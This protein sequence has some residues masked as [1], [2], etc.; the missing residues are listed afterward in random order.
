MLMFH[1]WQPDLPR[2]APVVE[3]RSVEFLMCEDY[4]IPQMAAPKYNIEPIF[5]KEL[6]MCDQLDRAIS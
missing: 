1:S 2:F 5:G 3:E 4:L 6:R